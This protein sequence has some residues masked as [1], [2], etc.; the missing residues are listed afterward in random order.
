MELSPLT[1]LEGFA[2]KKPVISSKTHGIPYTV[3][4]RKNSILVESENYRELGDA[5]LEL[6]NDEKK[7]FE[8]GADGYKLVIET[9]NA[10]TMADNT[11]NVYQ[12][13]INK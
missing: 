4:Q 6:I 3:Q 13:L 11:F 5:I 12:K 9:C 10:D 2:F 7:C 8:Y 1:P